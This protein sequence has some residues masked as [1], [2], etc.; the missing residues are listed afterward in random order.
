VLRVLAEA[1]VPLRLA[2]V[3]QKTGLQKTIVF[4]LLKTLVA[5]RFVEQEVETR[6]FHIG[7]GAFEVAQAY[8]HGSSL[9]GLAQRHLQMLVEGSSHTAYLATLDGFEIVY[10]TSM[11]GTGPLRVHVNPG[12]RNPAYATAVGKALLAELDDVEIAERAEEFGLARLTS[13]TVT[14]SDELLRQV[15]EVRERGYALNCEEAYPGIGAIAAVIRDSSGKVSAG[16]T[17]SYATSLLA[18][19]ELPG[20]I[21][22]TTATALEISAALGTLPA[23]QRFVA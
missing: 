15:H 9:I 21:E 4:R 14:T 20:W 12:G 1:G 2:E 17:L 18:Q 22:R 19:D 7:I 23:D 10:L 5:S 16:I 13:T 3:Q 6:R 11:E 8:P